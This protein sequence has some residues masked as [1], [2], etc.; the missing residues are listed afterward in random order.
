MKRRGQAILVGVAIIVSVLVV[1]LVMLGIKSYMLSAKQNDATLRTYQ[2]F[3]VS[4]TKSTELKTKEALSNAYYIVN[5]EYN[6]VSFADNFSK[7]IEPENKDSISDRIVTMPLYEYESDYTIKSYPDYRMYYFKSLNKTI[8]VIINNKLLHMEIDVSKSDDMIKQIFGDKN[9][10]ITNIFDITPINY[11]YSFNPTNDKVSNI[12][13][14]D[15]VIMESMPRTLT[16]ESEYRIFK[17]LVPNFTTC[18]NVNLYLRNKN[19]KLVYSTEPG[20]SAIIPCSS[21]GLFVE[22]PDYM[23]TLLPN[24]VLK[25]ALDYYNIKYLVE[26]YTYLISIPSDPLYSNRGIMNPFSYGKLLFGDINKNTY[27]NTSNDVN[28][29]EVINEDNTLNPSVPKVTVHYNDYFGTIIHDVSDWGPVRIGDLYGKIDGYNPYNSFELKK[30]IIFNVLYMPPSITNMSLFEN[31]SLLGITPLIPL[32]LNDNRLNDFSNVS[33]VR[34]IYIDMFDTYSSPYKYINYYGMIRKNMVTK[35]NL[36]K[37]DYSSYFVNVMPYINGKFVEEYYGFEDYSGRYNLSKEQYILYNMNSGLESV[38]VSPIGL[39]LLPTMQYEIES[40][41]Y[42]GYPAFAI[43]SDMDINGNNKKVVFLEY[44]DLDDI[45]SK[46]FDS[47]TSDDYYTLE[48]YTIPYTIEA[49]RVTSLPHNMKPIDMNY[50][51]Y[52]ITTVFSYYGDIASRNYILNGGS[53]DINDYEKYTITSRPIPYSIWTDGNLAGTSNYYINSFV[54]GPLN[55]YTITLIDLYTLFTHNTYP[56]PDDISV[57]F[58]ERLNQMP[59]MVSKGVENP[60]PITLRDI[61]NNSRYYISG[62]ASD[63]VVKVPIAWIDND[64]LVSL[65]DTRFSFIVRD[66]SPQRNILL[67]YLWVPGYVYSN[68][69]TRSDFI[70]GLIY[71]WVV[72]YDGDKY[73]SYNPKNYVNNYK[74]VTTFRNFAGIQL[75][76][77]DLEKWW[78]KKIIPYEISLNSDELLSR[79]ISLSELFG[80]HP[81]DYK[82]DPEYGITISSLVPSMIWFN[83]KNIQTYNNASYQSDYLYENNYYISASH[84]NEINP[85][86]NFD[87]SM[88]NVTEIVYRYTIDSTPQSIR[89]GNCTYKVTP[90]N[91][92]V[93]SCDNGWMSSGYII[94]DTSSV[95]SSS[96]PGDRIGTVYVHQS[97]GTTYVEYNTQVT[98]KMNKSGICYKICELKPGEEYSIRITKTLTY[99]YYFYPDKKERID[100]P[101]SAIVKDGKLETLTIGS[102]KINDPKEDSYVLVR[103]N[104]PDVAYSGYFIAY[105]G[106]SNIVVSY[107]DNT[108][109]CSAYID[110]PVKLYKFEATIPLV[111]DL[112]T[113]DNITLNVIIGGKYYAFDNY[114]LLYGQ[115]YPPITV[116]TSSDETIDTV[117][118]LMIPITLQYLLSVNSWYNFIVPTHLGEES[119]LF[120]DVFGKMNNGYGR[121]VKLV[122]MSPV[123]LTLTGQTIQFPVKMP[124]NNLNILLAYHRL[125][126]IDMKGVYSKYFGED[127]NGQ[128]LIISATS[129]YRTY[130]DVDTTYVLAKA[131]GMEEG[132]CYSSDELIDMAKNFDPNVSG[133]VEIQNYEENLPD[134]DVISMFLYLNNIYIYGVMKNIEF[135]THKN[136]IGIPTFESNQYKAYGGPMHLYN[137][138]D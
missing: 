121:D 31:M 75:Y 82:Y 100:V 20:V 13:F 5:A 44:S 77:F 63:D 97:K 105:V 133:V 38:F 51:N 90:Y 115:R 71:D 33:Y 128:E 107:D 131:I 84:Y 48:W 117:Y 74:L 116:L 85:K 119:N 1:G 88:I 49:I 35:S 17:I 70:R 19:G 15:Y 3:M 18:V 62:D 102:T 129:L 50:F 24:V 61:L 42:Y 95:C 112:L 135:N 30:S 60:I 39:T 110:L 126:G 114:M 57:I 134:Y 8:S 59:I 43:F 26:H 81:D 98:F 93:E 4:V 103:V 96:Y 9:V 14:G 118:D 106:S 137:I 64:M 2:K 11:D 127:S 78:N 12:Y 22:F 79:K 108:K 111:Y 67:K 92:T 16:P 76:K 123:Y 125:I 69:I 37:Y 28:V 124:I 45:L 36:E 32:S 86:N 6:M 87:E 55:R 52:V 68:N 27:Y 54:F 138:K 73:V 136:T 10:E 120:M 46:D 21:R 29:E 130:V 47:L 58:H 94:I 132:T 56:S 34:R 83:V 25:Y 72:Y 101:V 113:Y 23:N 109:N 89:I 122:Y 66:N 53:G 104:D 40:D 99:D 65:N 80:E 7:T 91:V 41:E